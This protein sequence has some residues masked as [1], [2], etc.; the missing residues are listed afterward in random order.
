M[1]HT[2]FVQLAEV[3][4]LKLKHDK[5]SKS[6]E[7]ENG[8]WDFV[9]IPCRVGTTLSIAASD[10]RGE[11]FRV[12]I[13]RSGDM[14][15]KPLI[16][17]ID[18]FD[19]KRALWKKGKGGKTKTEFTSDV[20]DVLYVVF[21]NPHSRKFN[22]LDISVAAE[23]PALTFKDEPLRESIEIEARYLEGIEVDAS[24]GDTIRVFGRVTKGNDIT[25]HVLSRMYET[26]DSYHADK[27]YFTKEKVDEI[28]IE[29]HCQKTEPL[30]VIF[31]N[32]YSMMTPKTVDV[33]VQVMK[34]RDQPSATPGVCRFCSAKIEVG[35]PFCPHCGGKQ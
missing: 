28:E 4:I 9:E 17:T 20:H 19:E 5:L 15:K 25:V 1:K 16:G 18:G 2:W 24:S 27:S 32:S 26:P 3:S 6:I 8:M 14:K 13:I 33:T 35:L 12:Y 30:L 11:D 34:G 10:D 23:H 22:Y 29:Y 21:E 31:D 7:L